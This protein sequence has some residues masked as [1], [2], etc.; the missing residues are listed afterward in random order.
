MT[1][2]KCKKKQY[3][4]FPDWL[5]LVR[6]YPPPPPLSPPALFHKPSPS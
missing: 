5:I 3:S 6:N 1:N 2:L 4:R